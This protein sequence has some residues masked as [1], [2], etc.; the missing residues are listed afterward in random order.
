MS[1][2]FLH[3]SVFCLFCESSEEYNVEAFLKGLGFNVITSLVERFIFKNGKWKK[4]LRSI[5]PGYVFFEHAGEPLWEKIYENEHIYYALH[6]SDKSKNLKAHDL[7]FIQW[8]KKQNGKIKTS[9]AIEIENKIKILEGPLKELE[10]KII[11]INKKQKSACVKIEG[12]GI[13]NKI[14]LSY[15]NIE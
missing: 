3:N 12:E 11:K 13:I 10:G 14:W 15:E 8:L 7:N 1:E 9:K 6:Y 4:E 5:I 2:K